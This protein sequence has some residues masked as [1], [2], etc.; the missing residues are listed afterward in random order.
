[1]RM[2][3]TDCMQ[4][5]KMPIGAKSMSLG[6]SL[7]PLHIAL[8]VIFETLWGTGGAPGADSCIFLPYKHITFLKVEAC[9]L[10]RGG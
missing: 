3:F 1:M 7:S 5:V 2:V 4:Q 6:G 8:L 10:R 9:E